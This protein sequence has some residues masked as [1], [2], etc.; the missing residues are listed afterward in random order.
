[1]VGYQYTYLIGDLIVLAVWAFLFFR[2]KD[3]KKEM[4]TISLIFGIIAILLAPIYTKDWWQPLT[5]TGT[6]VGIEDFLFGF[7]IGGLTSVIYEHLFNR[8]IKTAKLTKKVKEEMKINLIIPLGAFIAT[9]I[10]CIFLF[11]LNSFISSTISL[12]ISILLIY[13]KRKDLIRNS[14]LSGISSS[15]FAFTGYH[16]LNMITPG[17]FNEFWLYKNIGKILFLG[18]PLEEIV[19][20]FLAGAFIGPLYEYWKEGKE[21]KT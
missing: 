6:S 4:L 16:L 11:N 2:R 3:T 7:G 10:L 9:F 18:V 20:F 5:I 1:M 14:L 13:L 17:F 15:I 12:T 8:R 19:W 21:V